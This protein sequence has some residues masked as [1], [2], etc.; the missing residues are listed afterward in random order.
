M[1]IAK[2]FR[3][4][5]FLHLFFFSFFRKPKMNLLISISTLCF[6]SLVAGIPAKAYNGAKDFDRAETKEEANRQK[7]GAYVPKV[8]TT[9]IPKP[10]TQPPPNFVYDVPCANRHEHC[11]ANRPC[12]TDYPKICVTDRWGKSYCVFDLSKII[13][14]DGGN[15]MQRQRKTTWD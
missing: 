10:D 8:K 2:L 9:Q 4:I 11:D 3:L 14:N 15:I 1:G 5:H 7:D 13:W 12:C 6:V